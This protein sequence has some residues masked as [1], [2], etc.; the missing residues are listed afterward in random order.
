MRTQ[1]PSLGFPMQGEHWLTN[2][3]KK[4]KDQLDD[5]AKKQMQVLGKMHES[6]RQA[7]MHR[8]RVENLEKNLKKSKKPRSV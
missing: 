6:K 8:D 1:E 4:L 2:S 5:D 3:I 7:D